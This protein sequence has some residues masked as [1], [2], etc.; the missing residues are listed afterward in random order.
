[1]YSI[2][3]VM[4]T[5]LPWN[6]LLPSKPIRLHHHHHRSSS[7]QAFRRSDFD[8]FARRMA[9]GEVWRDV[10][11]SANDGFEQL[12]YETKKTAERIDRRYSVSRRLSAV[13]QSASYRAREIDRDLEITQ[14]WRTFTLDFS[15]NWPRLTLYLFI[16]VDNILHLVCTIW[17]AVSVLDIS[18]MDTAICG[19]SSH[20][21]SCQ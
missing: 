7:V 21:N 18:N 14:R 3:V 17:M 13:A 12:L 20:W 5:S 16:C 2:C 15:R 8:G 4:A 10:W 19:S 11:R 1:M 9:S 6:P